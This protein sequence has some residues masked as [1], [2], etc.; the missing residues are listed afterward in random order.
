MWRSS[1]WSCRACRT[2]PASTSRATIFGS[3]RSA[4]VAGPA[5]SSRAAG[6]MARRS[7]SSASSVPN[8][9]VPS[10]PLATSSIRGAGS[11]PADSVR[12]RSTSAV[13]GLERGR[14]QSSRRAAGPRRDDELGP[15][16]R[17]DDQGPRRDQRGDLGV[18]ELLQQPEDVPIDRLS[19]DV[20]AV[21]EVAADAD[22]LDPRVERRGIQRDRPSL[23]VAEDPDAQLPP[24]VPAFPLERIDQGQHLLDL[25][26]DHVP[27]QLE[28]RAVDELA[29]GEPAPAR[30]GTPPSDRSTPGRTRGNDSRPAGGPPGT[31]A[32]RPAPARR[33]ARASG[34]RR[35]P[36]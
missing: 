7:F 30:C 3:G 23:A 11:S 33:A 8:G 15:P 36:R 5:G 18:A 19:P 31:P 6:S 14:R 34:R 10:G 16:G 12:A 21:V 22:G 32:A 25:V 2:R 35:G 17:L 28:G 29:V 20:V 27:A 9:P 13:D 1:S 24:A 4:A 26:A